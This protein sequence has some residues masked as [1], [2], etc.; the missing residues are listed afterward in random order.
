MKVLLDARPLL[1]TRMGIGYYCYNLI[2]A[3]KNVDTISQYIPVYN[4][5]RTMPQQVPGEELYIRFPFRRINESSFLS[6]LFGFISLETFTGDFDIYHGTAFRLIPAKAKKVLTIHDLAYKY[7]PETF[8]AKNYKFLTRMVG[9]YAKQ[10]DH[11]ITV[12]E[13]TKRDV[14]RFLDVDPSKVTVTHLAAD[15]IF[16][17]IESHN[18]QLKNVRQKYNLPEKFVL[19]VGTLEPRKNLPNLIRAFHQMKKRTCC[20]HKLVLAGKKGWLYEEISRTIEELKMGSE[21]ILP[22]YIAAEDLPYLYNLAD[23]FAYVSKYE[24]FGLPPLEAMQCGIPV[25]VANT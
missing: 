5:F 22:D 4:T 1:G 13:S 2:M 25:M 17:P 12:S 16:R 9:I 19:Y 3:L 18:Q 7:Y 20:E 6:K 10:A 14:I 23:V 8:D 15:R 11:I 21:I 24:G